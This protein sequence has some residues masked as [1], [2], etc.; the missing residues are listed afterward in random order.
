MLHDWSTQKIADAAL[1]SPSEH[2]KTRLASRNIITS[3]LE[4]TKLVSLCLLFFLVL[5]LI[6]RL[7]ISF[8]TSSL[9][10][11]CGWGLNTASLNLNYFTHTLYFCV[12]NPFMFA[13]L[14]PAQSTYY[15]SFE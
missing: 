13:K 4:L 11:R 1:S 6:N 12:L 7:S 5:K 2:A 3:F 9:Y 10:T 14:K 8:L 15:L